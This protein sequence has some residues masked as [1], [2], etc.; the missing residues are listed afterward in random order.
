MSANFYKNEMDR[1]MLLNIEIQKQ[2]L[3]ALPER[4][5]AQKKVVSPVTQQM[6]DDYKQQFRDSYKR[7]DDKGSSKFYKFLI[8][9]AEPTLEIIDEDELL[10]SG[11]LEKTLEPDEIKE[12]IIKLEKL[13]ERY[14]EIQNT[15]IP[16][17]YENI[18]LAKK[19]I[20]ELMAKKRALMIKY[21][22]GYIDS[23]NANRQ[24]LLK[25]YQLSNNNKN[26]KKNK[27][28]Y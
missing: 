26:K 17:G 16:E 27:K 5:K 12:A 15:I 24:E 20:N 18:E 21:S 8:P 9:E 3:K 28:R 14:N 10:K 2:N 7:T 25:N 1:E 11:I 23:L 6:I 19:D 22:D 13:K 4:F